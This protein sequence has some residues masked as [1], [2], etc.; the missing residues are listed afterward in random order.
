MTAATRPP[1]DLAPP[2]PRAACVGHHDLFDGRDAGE[3]DESVAARHAAAQMLCSRC[4][5]LITCATWYLGTPKKRRPIGVT[6]G[7]VLELTTTGKVASG[8]G[9]GR[10]RKASA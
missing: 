1:L 6:A 10:P 4:P 7:E 8:L 5:E 3:S 9:R 2:M